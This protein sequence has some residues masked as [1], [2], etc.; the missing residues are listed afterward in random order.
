MLSAADPADR[1]VEQEDFPLREAFGRNRQ[2]CTRLKAFPWQG[3]VPPT[4]TDE[5]EACLLHKLT[6]RIKSAEHPRGGALFCIYVYYYGKE[7][8]LCRSGF[9]AC[10]SRR[11][12]MRGMAISHTRIVTTGPRTS[13]I[14]SA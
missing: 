5:V 11:R 3:K 13:E 7:T 4:A 10:C 14:G 12:R 8:Q 2:C 9:S 6:D 1:R